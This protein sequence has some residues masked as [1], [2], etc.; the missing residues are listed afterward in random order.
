MESGEENRKRRIGIYGGTFDPVHIG[1]LEAAKAFLR[2]AELDCLYVIPTGVTPHKQNRAGDDP[3]KRLAMLELAFADPAYA[4]PRIIVS[5]YEQKKEGKSY[6]IHTLEHFAAEDS[7]LFLLCGTDMFLTLENWMRGEDILKMV[8]V[9]C[10]ERE[11]GEEETHRLV[12]DTAQRYRDTYGA[13]IL[14]PVYEPVVCSS[15]EVRRRIAAGLS[16]DGLLTSAVRGYILENRLY[17][18]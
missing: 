15:T 1:H 9:V 5:D 14:L 3:A 7:R 4:D 16:T 8:T 10:F 2:A 13:D 12:L 18:E 6:T 17:T 11:C